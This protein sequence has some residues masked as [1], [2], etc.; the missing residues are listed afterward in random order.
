MTRSQNSISAGTLTG[1]G[2]ELWEV[3]SIIT[4]CLIAEWALV[5][6]VGGRGFLTGVPVVLALGLMVFS[7]WYRGEDL[8]TIGF[9]LDNFGAAS[10]I[11]VLPTLAAVIVILV[12]GG[13]LSSAGLRFRPLRPHLFLLPLWALFQQYALQ[14]FINRRLQSS[15]GKGFK[16][17]LLVGLL[18]GLLHLP[19]PLLALLTFLGG[20]I[21]AHA[22]QR[23]PNLLALGVSHAIASLTLAFAIPPNLINGLRVGFRYFN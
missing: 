18:F 11:L 20:L 2:L 7:H 4:S 9:R 14:G 8:K 16:V 13:I 15:L 19:N 3:A 5:P 6:F 17:T 12:L 23:Q 22:Y 21:C 10:R 1:Q